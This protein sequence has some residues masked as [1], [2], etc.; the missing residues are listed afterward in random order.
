MTGYVSKKVRRPSGRRT[1]VV[2]ASE[3]EKRIAANL[4]QL[5]RDYTELAKL[6]AAKGESTLQRYNVG[7]SAPK[8]TVAA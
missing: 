3:I 1:K 2:E 8:R 4:K 7:A 5:D 6:T